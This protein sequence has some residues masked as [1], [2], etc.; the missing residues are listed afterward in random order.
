METHRRTLVKS[1]IWRII[2]IVWTWLGAYI[3]LLLIP[4]SQSAAAIAASA[5][6]LYHHSPRLFM[7]YG[8]E[9]VWGSIGWGRDEPAAQIGMAEKVSWIGGAVVAFALI[10]LLSMTLKH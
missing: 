5:I 3:I 8:Y 7:Y 1:V 4:P 10:I 9:R 2:G 6:V